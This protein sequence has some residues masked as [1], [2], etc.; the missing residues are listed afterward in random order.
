MSPGIRNVV[1]VLSMCNFPS[2]L[3]VTIGRHIVY[4]HSQTNDEMILFL[5]TA[6]IY[7]PSLFVDRYIKSRSKI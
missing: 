4:I 5:A 3:E 6:T 2:V 1:G 7:S